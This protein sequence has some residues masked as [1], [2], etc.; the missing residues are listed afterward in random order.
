[1]TIGHVLTA[2]R[3]NDGLVVF[4]TP[5]N[6]WSGNIDEAVLAQEEKAA[7]ALERRGNEF[8]GANVVTGA[9]MV[10]AQR[11]GGMI[12]PTHVRERIR[13]CGPTVAYLAERTPPC[14]AQGSAIA[15]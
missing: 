10:E 11:T 8:E 6:T 14:A 4:L 7:A 2:N 3:L 5:A 12:T 15:A 13:A 9:Y 1:M